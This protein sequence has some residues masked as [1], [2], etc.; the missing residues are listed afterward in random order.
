MNIHKVRKAVGVFNHWKWW[1][2]IRIG[3]ASTT[4]YAT[5]NRYSKTFPDS[6]LIESLLNLDRNQKEEIASAMEIH[7]EKL[8]MM[9]S[10]LRTL[11]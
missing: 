6:D 8:C 11:H 10:W 7:L 4:R 3:H 1:P 9:V 5:A 2:F